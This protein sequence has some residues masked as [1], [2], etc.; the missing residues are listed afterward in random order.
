[1]SYKFE[2]L[3]KY[4]D[5][6]DV[7]IIPKSST[8]N[9]RSEVDLNRTITFN[10]GKTWT[11]IPIVAANMT[12]IGTLDMYKVL[13][14]NKIITALHKFH[15]LENLLEYN[16]NNP[17][18]PLD[19]NFFM[20][21]TGIGDKDFENLQNILDN[22]DCMFICIDVANG[23]ISKFKEFCK[24]VRAQYKDKVILAG[25]VSTRDGVN[26][27]I[28]IGIDIIKT[29][30][31]GGSACTTRIQT[32]IGMPQLSCLIE[33]SDECYN[34]NSRCKNCKNCEICET[35]GNCENYN[36]NS[37][38]LCD[39]GITCPGDL[40]KAFGAGADFIMIGGEF[41][42]HDEN[43]GKLIEDEKT[44][45]KYKFFYG[46]SSGYA[47]ENNYAANNNTSYRSSEGREIKIKYKGSLQKTVDNYLGGLRSTCTYTNSAN[48]EKLEEN[49]K[50]ILVNNQYNSN[51][52]E[53]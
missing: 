52:V 41:S 19:P 2:S 26:E 34:C 36:Y 37:Y 30:I 48:I 38:I 31:G 35:Y 5:F 17:E 23:Y 45:E 20:I 12:T 11:G 44:G 40:G 21:S 39:G 28:N 6:K 29:G 43:P 49:C 47:M 16:K 46:M 13:N 27:L 14:K 50:F 7:L 24:K 42:G 32:G 10:N 15:T 25:N 1:M 33:A 53:K 3:Y 22:F 8:L 51:L 4:F 9:S 18:T